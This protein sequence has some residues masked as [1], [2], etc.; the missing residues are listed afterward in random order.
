MYN[1][2]VFLFRESIVLHKLKTSCP[3]SPPKNCPDRTKI[4]NNNDPINDYY[5]A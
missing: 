1:L 4:I 2:Q 3:N 5:I